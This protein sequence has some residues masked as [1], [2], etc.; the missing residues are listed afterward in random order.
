MLE[1][2][3]CCPVLRRVAARRLRVHMPVEQFR[4][5][6][7]LAVPRTHDERSLLATLR[8]AALVH[9]ALHRVVNVARHHPAWDASSMAEHAL[10]Q[11]MIEGL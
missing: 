7:L 3:C 8:K 2:Y 11:A 4:L 10:E 1:Q 9:Y 6:M 5:H